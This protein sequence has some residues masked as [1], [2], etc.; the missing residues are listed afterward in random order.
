M[1]TRMCMHIYDN[2]HDSMYMNVIVIYAYAMYVCTYV[3]MCNMQCMYVCMCN[4]VLC[5]HECV[6][7]IYVCVCI[8]VCIVVYDEM[9]ICMCM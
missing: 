1:N 6:H 9:Y 7:N 2:V 8:H 4:S 5:L 3:Y